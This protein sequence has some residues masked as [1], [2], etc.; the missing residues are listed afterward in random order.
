MCA[1]FPPGRV[2]IFTSAAAGPCRNWAS[3]RVSTVTGPCATYFHIAIAVDC[4]RS[5]A[6]RGLGVLYHEIAK[7]DP[8]DASATVA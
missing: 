2:H 4:G 6:V 1:W 7:A 3:R 8:L 5:R